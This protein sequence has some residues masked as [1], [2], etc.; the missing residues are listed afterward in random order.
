M[1]LT[2]QDKKILRENGFYDAETAPSKRELERDLE[3][4]RQKLH[5]MENKE[6]MKPKDA[7]NLKRKRL[8]INGLYELESLYEQC[9]HPDTVTLALLAKKHNKTTQYVNAWFRKKRHV[10]KKLQKQITG[11]PNKLSPF[12]VL[13]F[14]DAVEAEIDE[15][16]NDFNAQQKRLN[17]DD[18]GKRSCRTDHQD[19]Q[20]N[21]T[22]HELQTEN[23]GN[24]QHNNRCRSGLI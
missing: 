24:D 17:E 3:I 10:D 5:S 1:V 21:N 8:S 11:E 22:V 23:I 4:G 16:I 6:N 12:A 9:K 19:Q 13:E 7:Q 20:H 18:L 14:R 15:V 2:K